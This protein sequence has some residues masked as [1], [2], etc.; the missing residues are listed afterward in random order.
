[1]IIKVDKLEFEI[2]DDSKYDCIARVGF[3]NMFY[4][5]EVRER[6]LDL[7]E[8][9]SIGT[10]YLLKEEWIKYKEQY[11]KAVSLYDKLKILV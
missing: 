8:N 11:I 10:Q 4:C 9:L 1:M 2:S 6:K 7:T 3:C 5:D